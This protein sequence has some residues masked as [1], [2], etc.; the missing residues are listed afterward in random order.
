M[1][2]HRVPSDTDDTAMFG[3]LQVIIPEKSMGGVSNI[4]AGKGLLPQNVSFSG[5]RFC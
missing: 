1:G 3:Y 5:K 4:G 2:D